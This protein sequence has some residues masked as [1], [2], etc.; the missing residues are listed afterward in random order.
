MGKT[1]PRGSLVVKG[2][3]AW[4]S[5]LKGPSREISIEKQFKSA[6]VRNGCTST[7][8]DGNH[9]REGGGA[10]RKGDIGFPNEFP[11]GRDRKGVV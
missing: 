11:G 2:R 10:G 3:E 5:Y 6:K 8:A 7:G 9:T 1:S 4:R